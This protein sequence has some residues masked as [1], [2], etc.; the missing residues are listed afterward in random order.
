[1]KKKEVENRI[2]DWLKRLNELYDRVDYWRQSLPQTEV[3]PGQI[4]QREEEP[5]RE[6]KVK[7]RPVP[8]YTVLMGKKRLSFVPAALWILG[9]NGR[10]NVSTN[11]GHYMLVDLKGEND[12]QSDWRIVTPNINKIHAPFNEKTFKQLLLKG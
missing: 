3:L 2:G 6:C 9:A 12:A 5:M 1:M 7:P 8:T 4:S 10:V 11:K